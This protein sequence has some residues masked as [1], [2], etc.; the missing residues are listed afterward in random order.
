M[1]AKSELSSL[2][3]SGLIRLAALEPDIEYLFRHALVQDA[4]Y[5]SLTKQDRRGLHARAAQVL[6]S[7]YPQREREL[8]AVLGM[9]LE[10]A[11]DTA[12]AVR[13]FVD[14]GEHAV[15]RFANQEAVAFFDRAY[16]DAPNDAKD[17]PT[18]EL[19]VRAAIGAVK[20]GWMFPEADTA[21]VRLDEAIGSADGIVGPRLLADALFWTIFLRQTRG[22]NEMSSPDLR[23]MRERLD[24]IG[25]AI[26]DPVALAPAEA[27]SGIFMVSTG[28]MRA[29]A[30]RLERALSV[31]EQRGDPYSAGLLA[32][33]LSSTYARLGEFDAAE[34]ALATSQRLSKT[35]DAIARLD[36]TIAGATIAFERGHAVD[37]AA[38]ASA[39]A[40]EAEDLGAVACSIFSNLTVG[41]ARLE[42]GEPSSAKPA[43]ERVHELSTLAKM[44]FTRTLARGWLTAV[45]ARIGP[46]P[47]DDQWDAALRSARQTGDRF[48]EATI[49]RQRALGMVV[50]TDPD[51]PAIR[52]ELDRAAALFEACEARPALVRTLRDTARALDALDRAAEAAAARDRAAELARAIGMSDQPP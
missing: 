51:W 5:S 49:H 52:E 32:N 43:L 39:C 22:E 17:A 40:V 35:G 33:V 12:G 25:A 2:E 18:V 1:T 26:E 9:H 48:Q 21:L 41:E 10:Q 50:G 42:L 7:L 8:G 20:A 24:M 31:L 23:A 46:P 11:G 6:L 45:E 14:A 44:D 34:R 16:R 15:E 36:S 37:S 19:R 47:G 13:H 27:L 29:G 3:A 4:A 28:Q 38:A 30:A